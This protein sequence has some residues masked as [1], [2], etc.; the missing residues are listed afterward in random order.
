MYKYA[1]TLFLIYSFD[2]DDMKSSKRPVVLLSLIFLLK[3]FS[4]LF[5]IIMAIG[6]GISI[7]ISISISIRIRI[8]IRI[9]N[10]RVLSVVQYCGLA[11]V[12]TAEADKLTV[13]LKFEVS[14]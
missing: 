6:I 14:I 12:E 3:C 2:N 8:S 13:C 10:H 11:S 9:G 5:F 7:S 4:T 1:F